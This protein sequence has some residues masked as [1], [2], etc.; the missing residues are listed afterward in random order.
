[1]NLYSLDIK[2]VIIYN[3]KADACDEH[4]VRIYVNGVFCYST[5]GRGARLVE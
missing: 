1:M 4:F 2:N 5:N 3:E